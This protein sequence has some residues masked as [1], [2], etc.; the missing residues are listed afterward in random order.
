MSIY[1]LYDET[2]AV[3]FRYLTPTRLLGPLP[4]PYETSMTPNLY[5][6]YAISDFQEKSDRGFVNAFTNTKRAL[7]LTI[8]TLLNQYGLFKYYK[9]SNFPEKLKVLDSVGILPITIIQNLN[10]ERNLIEH[11]Y[12]V[13]SEKRV[14]EAIDV[15]KLLLLASEKLQHATPHE[16]IIGWKYPKLHLVMQL[17]PILGILNLFKIRAKGKYRKINGIS[18][19]SGRLR[20]LRGNLVS[21]IQIAKSPWRV[22]KLNKSEISHWRPIISEL[23]NVQRKRHAQTTHIDKDSASFTIPVTIPLP[24]LHKMT[25]AKLL[26]K[27]IKNESKEKTNKVEE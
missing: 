16:A 27:F 10:V 5:L 13:P 9:K 4:P 17:E 14:G 2:E 20:D 3:P 26:D 6:E 23:V 1:F 19:F 25:W 21:D 22:I 7:H 8:D 11:K 24:S 12:G 15:A 18:C